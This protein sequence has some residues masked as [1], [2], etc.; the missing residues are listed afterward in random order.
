MSPRKSVNEYNS[1]PMVTQGEG[2]N[3][4][5]TEQVNVCIQEVYDLI[6]NPPLDLQ[7]KLERIRILANQSLQENGRESTPSLKDKIY[8]LKKE[9][10][11]FTISGTFPSGERRKEKLIQHSGRLQIDVD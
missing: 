7:Q 9:L 1:L 11:T 6:Q 8:T 10:P 3:W 2:I 5:D 4:K